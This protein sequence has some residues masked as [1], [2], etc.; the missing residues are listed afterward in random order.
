M[1]I[2]SALVGAAAMTVLSAAPALAAAPTPPPQYPPA[3]ITP[4][5]SPS[6]AASPSASPAA[7][8]SATITITNNGLV[9]VLVGLK[10]G[11]TVTI[12]VS[13]SVNTV[14][15]NRI[16]PFQVQQAVF[17]AAPAIAPAATLTATKSA[18][19]A[20]N[21][22]ATFDFSPADFGLSSFK[23]ATAA[24]TFTGV[25]ASG[26]VVSS[27]TSSSGG[28]ASLGLGNS[29]PGNKGKTKSGRGN[30]LGPV[31]APN[32]GSGSSGLPFTGAAAIIPTVTVGLLLV[33]A[34]G[35]AIG[36]SRRRQAKLQG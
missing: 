34:G 20:A 13:I 25:S 27:S 17:H 3:T 24:A 12:T 30:D 5:P 29:K 7:T 18:I 14:A 23:G 16:A 26:A 10:P 32:I 19:V 6:P 15:L 22:T 31:T 2:A 4:P 33:A 35:T 1:K 8:P 36:A 28:G 11:T 9:T 21:G